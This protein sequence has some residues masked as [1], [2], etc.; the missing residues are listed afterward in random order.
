MEQVN[1]DYYFI[2][3]D[4]KKIGVI[5]IVRQDNETNRISPLFILPQYQGQCYAKQTLR[6]AEQQYPQ[7]KLWRLDTI[8][9]ESKL[10][11]LYTKA[12][13]HLTGREEKV[14]EGMTLAYY[15]K[16]IIS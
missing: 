11:Y 8:K 16:R 2:Q 9:E 13:Y 5:R 1:T 6:L 4:N 3:R 7:V 15:E 10:S 12:G 14:Q